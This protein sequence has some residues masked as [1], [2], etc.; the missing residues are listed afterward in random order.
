MPSRRSLGC[1]G[2]FVLLSL[3]S[4]LPTGPE[5]ISYVPQLSSATLAAKL[6]QTTFTLEQ[7]QGQFNHLNISDFDPIWL[8]VARS[9]GGCH[10]GQPRFSLCEMGRGRARGGAARNVVG[11][12]EGSGLAGQAG[13]LPMWP[14]LSDPHA[15]LSCPEHHCPREGGGL[16]G[17]CRPPPEGLLPHADGQPGALSRWPAWQ[18][19]PGPPRWQ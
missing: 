1:G 4:L 6:T 13:A 10:G 7:P 12:E 16:S 19:A 15:T 18:P 9:N 17:P 8:V 5:H 2:L 11:V 14:L 3:F